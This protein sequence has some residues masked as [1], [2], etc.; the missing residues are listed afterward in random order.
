MRFSGFQLF[1]RTENFRAQILLQTFSH[2]EDSFIVSAQITTQ[3]PTSLNFVPSPRTSNS[4]QTHYNSSKME[5]MSSTSGIVTRPKFAKL[6]A[7][8]SCYQLIIGQCCVYMPSFGRRAVEFQLCRMIVLK[9]HYGLILLWFF[10]NLRVPLSSQQFEAAW[11]FTSFY[12][13][14][15]LFVKMNLMKW[16][17]IY[18]H[19]LIY[20]CRLYLSAAA[21]TEWLTRRQH[22]RQNTYKKGQWKQS[23]TEF[24]LFFLL[25]RSGKRRTHWIYD[26]VVVAVM[27]I[28]LWGFSD[29]HVGI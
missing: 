19:N 15:Y 9:C 20:F 25:P 29:I 13:L 16:S 3:A 18:F 28:R 7:W 21:A 17:H 1:E 22:G 6:L 24:L 14:W 5:I 4:K 8:P 26:F 11:D 10:P 27:G 12:M 2:H 23:Q